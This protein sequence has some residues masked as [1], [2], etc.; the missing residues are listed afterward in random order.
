MAVT[1][2]ISRRGLNAMIG[3][4]QR[5]GFKAALGMTLA[6]PKITG[7]NEAKWFD[8]SHLVFYPPGAVPVSLTSRCRFK[9][10]T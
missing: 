5:I 2:V 3:E 4:A 8:Q 10:G 1:G 6:R 7:G 9:D